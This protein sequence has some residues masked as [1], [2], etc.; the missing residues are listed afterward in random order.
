V[1]KVVEIDV[2]SIKPTLLMLPFEV[3][4]NSPKYKTIVKLTSFNDY[5]EEVIPPVT[6]VHQCF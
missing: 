3:F 4:D 5:F 2:P 6:N 1:K